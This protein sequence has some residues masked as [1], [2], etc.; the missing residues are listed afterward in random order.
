MITYYYKII[1]K[2]LHTITAIVTYY[3]KSLLHIITYSYS[4]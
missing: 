2:L 3:Y 4:Y 1:T